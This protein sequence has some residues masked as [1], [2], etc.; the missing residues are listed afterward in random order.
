MAAI[1]Q[2]LDALG[3]SASIQDDDLI[4]DAVVILK[5][6]E[7]DGSVRLS[8]AWSEGMSWIE[9]LGMVTAAKACEMP[10]PEDILPADDGA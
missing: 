6:L 3:V 9:R 4:T 7:G 2:N 10:K 8:T 1:G 5:V